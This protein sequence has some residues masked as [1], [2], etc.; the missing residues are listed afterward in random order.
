MII[1]WIFFIIYVLSAGAVYLWDKLVSGTAVMSWV[2][3]SQMFTPIHNTVVAIQLW[4]DYNPLN[5]K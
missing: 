5:K 3:E 4:R 2:K 1:F